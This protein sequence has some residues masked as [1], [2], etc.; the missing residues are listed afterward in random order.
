MSASVP[1]PRSEGR[2]FALPK[3]TFW[4]L[5]AAASIAVGLYATYVR[6]FEGIGAA[7]G[8]TDARPWG[9]WVAF[10]VLCGVGLAAGGF[11]ITAAVHLFGLKH[12]KPIVRPAV[13]TAFLG[14]TLVSAGLIFDLGKPWNIWHPVIMWNHHSVMFEVAWCV[15]LYSTVMALEFSPVVFER[16]GW[17]KPL[18]IV[19]KFTIP[20]VLAGVLLSTMHQSSLGTVFLIAPSKVH[21]LWYS[22]ALPIFFFVS[23]VAVGLSMVIFESYLSFRFLGHRLKPQVLG[24]LARGSVVV[25]SLYFVM[26]AFDLVFRGAVG[27]LFEAGIEAPLFAAELGLGVLLPIFL[28]ASER[29]RN[30]R[31]G[32]FIA[33]TLVVLG[34]VLGRLNVGLT[35]FDASQGTYFPSFLEL[36]ITVMLV[37]IGFV[38]FGLAAK[39]LPIFGDHSE[40]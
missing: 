38:T 15:M 25:L 28:F 9:I 31:R 13:L 12:L 20:L 8:L 24:S 16:F 19:H 40:H 10:D 37:V 14:Y 2:S 26:R 22:T 1:A 18:K 33:A 30:S 39:H 11:T 21:P 4:R 27:H 29:V 6:F 7:S 23:A 3:I 36:S 34:F 17:A 32:L 5:F 35:A